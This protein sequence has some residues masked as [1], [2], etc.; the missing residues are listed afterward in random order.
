[1]ALPT[2]KKKPVPGAVAWVAVIRALL[3]DWK[4]W[5]LP[6]VLIVGAVFWIY[7]PVLHGGFIWDDEWYIVLNPLLHHV[8]GLWKFWF[9]PGSW[10]EYY[11]ISETVLWTQWQLWGHDTLGYHLTNVVL[12]ILNAIWV[13]RLFRKL[14]LRLAWLGGLLFAVHPVQVE[15][16]AWIVE[17]KNTLS[18]FFFLLAAGCWIDYEERRKSQDYGAAL[19]LFLASMLG[20][21]AM[22]P[23]PVILLLYAW[24]K[25]GRI[26]VGDL[27]ASAP[28]FI[29]S[30]ALGILTVWSGHWYEQNSHAQVLDASLGGPLQRISLAGQVLAFYFTACFWPVDLTPLY[31][32]WP[33]DATLVTACLPWLVLAM[34]LVW[35]WR[36]RQ[37]WGRHVLLG[38]G[39]F[40]LNLAPFL[41][42]LGISYMHDSWVELQLLYGPI[43][44]LIGLVVAGLSGLENKLIGSLRVVGRA[45]VI[46]LV[47]LWVVDAHAY[48]GWFAN[49]E[50]FWTRTLQRDPNAWLPHH[51]LGCA[52]LEQGRYAEAAVELEKAVPLQP[53]F[54]DGYY[55]LGVALEKS[56]RTTEAEENY[57]QALKI[58]PANAK[59]YLNLAE[60]RKQSGKLPQAEALIRQ[61]LQID[62]NDP[63]LLIDLGDAL[64]RMN[65]LSEATATF[66]QVI[67]VDPDSL[68]A[69]YNLG[70][71]QMQ[72]GELP[73]AEAHLQAAVKLDPT[74]AAAHENLG[75]VL[76]LLGRFSEAIPQFEAVLQIDPHA[77]LARDNLGLALAQSGRIPE[78]IEQF[79]QALQIN[80]QDA[81]ARAALAQ[82]QRQNGAGQNGR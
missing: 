72:T 33:V 55:N 77:M 35:L 40:A 54:S 57:R 20:K 66:E 10:V 22:A 49:A 50:T 12:H 9:Q 2:H 80:P 29:I 26:S 3:A 19:G 82:L 13:W 39:F 56:G 27:K 70:M 15:S 61:G 78:A 79:Q 81:K 21:I 51:D 76:A 53:G 47:L 44:G 31:S 5:L 59:V 1:M 46:A 28:F 71:T 36:R 11:P 18:L 48:A 16:V 69:Q 41:G 6:V 42:F 34:L 45:V 25:R 24:W 38:L 43:I 64:L 4:A 7:G 58:N 73:G 8:S 74:V 32:K 37:G 65:R 67:A 63:S 68:Q 75:V 30:L 62:P 14:G 23:F 60:M 17:L 52:L